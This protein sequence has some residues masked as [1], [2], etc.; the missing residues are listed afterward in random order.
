MS[1]T[2][3]ALLWLPEPKTT[4][5]AGE[6]LARTLYRFPVTIAL[7]GEL[8]AGKTTFLQGFARGLGVHATLASPTYALEQRYKTSHGEFLHLDLFRLPEREA[9]RLLR[10]SD[11]H[12]GI[13]A[14]E[15]ADR[16][17][18]GLAEN[19]DVHLALREDRGGRTLEC[20]FR[21]VPLPARDTIE[22]W[23]EEVALPSHIRRHCDAVGAFA[24]RCGD[25][26]LE[27]G[28]IVRPLLLRRSSEL[29]DLF[30]FLDFHL[31][32]APRDL[33]RS[34]EPVV[35][36]EWRL[37]YEGLS[38]EAAA[39]R[40]LRERGFEALAAVI[41]T[42]GLSLPAGTGR[43]TTEQKILYY[44][45]KRVQVASVV[46]LEER[47]ADFRERYGG[48]KERPQA[49]LWFEEVRTV[50]RELFPEGAPS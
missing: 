28:V 18:R 33:E 1:T 22:R 38:H 17:P 27:R 36:N 2:D 19:A 47:F 43:G 16:A 42:H 5:R 39:A 49:K 26:V 23:W 20:A 44:A 11:Q 29:H 46:S 4:L 24:E 14:V 35:W 45:D 41:E 37:R 13:R 15:W 32:A 9:E 48:G 8:G 31:G 21:D 6:S 50:E 40:F 3:R 34:E 10:E 30:R 12:A 7:T 25:R